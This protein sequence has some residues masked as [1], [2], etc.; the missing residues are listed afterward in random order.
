M[1]Y[2]SNFDFSYKSALY[3][4]PSYKLYDFST[5][6][7][8]S[9]Y[10]PSFDFS[11]NKTEANSNTTT[12]SKYASYSLS[13]YTSTSSSYTSLKNTPLFNYSYAPA[14]YK[15][16]SFKY[17]N[18]YSR[19][20]S[21][22]FKPTFTQ[23]NF[24]SLTGSKKTSFNQS[25]YTYNPDKDFLANFTRTS[26]VNIN[27][28]RPGFVKEYGV[29]KVKLADGREVL[30]CRWSKFDKIKPEWNNALKCFEQAAADLGCDLVYSDMTRTVAESNAARAKKGKSVAKGG[31]SPH[32]YGVGTDFVLF[33]DGKELGQFTNLYKKVID[34]AIALSNNKIESG[35]YWRKKGERHHIELRDWETKYKNSKY[36]VG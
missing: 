30:A 20:L 18:I 6:T 14:N 24:G 32:N 10:T 33:K 26:G 11:L 3:S 15:L 36:L 9:S 2:I 31:Q 23:T 13:S 25:M 12:Y 16:N 7:Y 19:H 1:G 27:N 29:R 21:S 35:I 8:N 28:I 34:R 4:N 17:T 5:S 22:P